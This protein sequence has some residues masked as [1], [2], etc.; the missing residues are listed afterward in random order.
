MDMYVKINSRCHFA[1]YDVAE[2][3]SGFITVSLQPT[4]ATE[5]S[6]SLLNPTYANNVAG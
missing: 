2:Q 3:N 5:Y 4:F 1:N 6:V